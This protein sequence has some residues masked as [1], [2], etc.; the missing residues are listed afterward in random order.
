MEGAPHYT[1]P[2]Q[3]KQD[4]LSMFDNCLQYNPEGCKAQWLRD[5]AVKARAEFE[6]MWSSLDPE[7]LWEK[8]TQ[9]QV[10]MDT[11]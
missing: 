5:R 8:A 11:A 10:R 3:V 4:I 6:G 2:S 7:M 1:S 9:G